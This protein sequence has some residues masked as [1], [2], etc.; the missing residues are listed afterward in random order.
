MDYDN[1]PTNEP[2]GVVCYSYM[3]WWSRTADGE[4]TLLVRYN[5]S[6][7]EKLGTYSDPHWSSKLMRCCRMLSVRHY[8]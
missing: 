2:G 7:S 1:E 8:L 3:H 6:K 5:A 4:L